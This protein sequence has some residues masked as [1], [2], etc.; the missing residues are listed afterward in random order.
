MFKKGVVQK[1]DV[2]DYST[3]LLLNKF[4][5]ERKSSIDFYGTIVQGHKRFVRELERAK[6]SNITMPIYVECSRG[7][8]VMKRFP[9]GFKLK[10]RPGTLIK[11]ID[12]M[13]EK[14]GLEIVW[15]ENRDNMRLQMI[16]RLNEEEKCEKE[17]Q[18]N[19]EV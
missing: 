17:I 2:G 18:A 9:M 12:T 11:I 6:K 10:M 15:C 3:N 14:Y 7:D 5:I 19:R 8:F 16:K 13:T 1:L 4:H